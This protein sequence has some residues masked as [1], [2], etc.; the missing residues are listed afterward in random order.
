MRQ[1]VQWL[2]RR[3]IVCFL[4]ASFLVLCITNKTVDA[5]TKKQDGITWLIENDYV[6]SHLIESEIRAQKEITRRDFVTVLMKVAQGSLV[7]LQIKKPNNPLTKQMAAYYLARLLNLHM[8]LELNEF[9]DYKK[10]SKTCKP[11]V[12]AVTKCGIMTGE[13]KK[14]W[15]PSMKMTWEMVG[16]LMKEVLAAGWFEERQVTVMNNNGFFHISDVAMDQ[17]T[18]TLYV[19]DTYNNQIK[20]IK[21][22]KITVVA[23]K[24]LGVDANGISIGGYVDGSFEQVMFN[25]PTAIE[26]TEDGLYVL[27]TGNHVVRFLNLEKK[28]SITFSGSGKAG[29]SNGSAKVASYNEP[30]DMVIA[31]D[32][33]MYIADSGN[34]CIRVV[35]ENGAASTFAGSAGK[36]GYKDGTRLSA[37]FHYPT[38]LA[39]ADGMIYI[40][41]CGNQRVRLIKDGTVS[42]YAGTGSEIDYNTNEYL[43]GYQDGA[44]KNA[45]F[46]YPK[47]IAIDQ[48]GRVY[49]SDVG[50]SR[51]RMIENQMVTTPAGLGVNSY[52]KKI[53]WETYL[54]QPEGMWFDEDEDVLYVADSFLNHVICISFK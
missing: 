39:I 31:K 7:G 45:M 30:Q 20:A 41:D 22:G 32:G 52:V 4:I 26:V 43:G 54:V 14:L 10:V 40:A 8:D 37:L 1:R 12:S 24:N 5:G 53:T 29:S 50:N 46:Q 21:D 13:T 19:C 16:N 18:K 34:N 17:K 23:G 11:Y 48:K 38:G 33:K 6:P 51:V 44:V 35:D 28:T 27:D 47:K 3:G 2:G 25:R 15:K 42:T 49:I 9:E 36:A